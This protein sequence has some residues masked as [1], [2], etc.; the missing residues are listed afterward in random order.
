[1]KIFYIF[2]L[3]LSV[4]AFAQCKDSDKILY[5]VKE[6]INDNYVFFAVNNQYS[7]KHNISSIADYANGAINAA[8]NYIKQRSGADF[9]KKCKVKYMYVNYPEGMDENSPTTELYNLSKYKVSYTVDYTVK[10]GKYD[11]DF[12]VLLDHSYKVL[13]GDMIP[14]VIANPKFDKFIEI[15]SALKLVKAQK[16]YKGVI[17]GIGISY[18]PEI[19][20]FCWHIQ[21]EP[22][23]IPDKGQYS[24]RDYY[25][26]ANTGK[27]THVDEQVY[28][29]P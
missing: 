9:E 10:F 3:L 1:M 17:S 15:C 25:V 29:I 19:D 5:A 4:Q 20:S 6:M 24:V 11:Y 22:S 2:A 14:S 18:D 16:Q 13:S 12:S 21:E 26:N 7:S 8:G 27:L 23:S 28:N